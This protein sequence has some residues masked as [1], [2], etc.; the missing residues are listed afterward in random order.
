MAN[1][2][3]ENNR[4]FAELPRF[5][6][7]RFIFTPEAWRMNTLKGGIAVIPA[8][9]DP[10]TF[11]ILRDSVLNR[12]LGM[13]VHIPAHK[14]GVTIPYSDVRETHPEVAR[15]YQGEA[16]AERIS[17]IVETRVV[18]TPLY[19]QSSCSVLIYEKEGD[20]IGWHYD[21]NFS[22][23]RH[24]TALLSLVNESR[25]RQCLSSAELVVQTAAGM[26]TIPTPPNTLVLFEGA[27]VRH[28]VTPLRSNEKRIILSMTFC[29]NPT[30][31]PLLDLQRRFKDIAYIG[32]RALWT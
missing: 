17:G 32:I 9:A 21:H 6:D 15:F 28:T 2:D 27:V 14:R 16:L 8:F 11:Q 29:A 24:F 13:R 1:E 23:G 3:S 5:V 20:R 7:H 26:K 4:T 18:P 10:E 19:D 25:I 12:P 30:T 22:N 31:R